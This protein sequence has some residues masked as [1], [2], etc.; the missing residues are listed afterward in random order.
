MRSKSLKGGSRDH[1]RPTNPQ[2]SPG[3]CTLFGTLFGLLA[4]G[5]ACRVVDGAAQAAL[6]AWGVPAVCILGVI[7]W[8]TRDRWYW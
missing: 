3:L 8:A 7:A 1:H 5:L 4:I 6:L 2:G